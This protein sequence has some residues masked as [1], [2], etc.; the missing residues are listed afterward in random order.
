MPNSSSFARD[1]QLLKLSRDWKPADR[2]NEILSRLIKDNDPLVIEK[3][4]IISRDMGK[5]DAEEILR[6]MNPRMDVKTIL[7][8]ILLV[9]GI[10][11]ETSGDNKTGRKKI[12]IK[13]DMKSGYQEFFSNRRVSAAYIRGFVNALAPNN[14]V[15]EMDDYFS[16][17]IEDI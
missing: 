15:S 17:I 13:K 7:E 8:G 5:Q 12:M 10:T 1:W 16:L 4:E 14:K 3:I 9:S 11:Y 6:R 2:S